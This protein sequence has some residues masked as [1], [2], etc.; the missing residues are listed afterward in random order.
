MTLTDKTVVPEFDEID[1]AW[2]QVAVVQA[3]LAANPKRDERATDPPDTPQFS[4]LASA[5]IRHLSA[6]IGQLEELRNV[7]EPED[8]YG[9][10]RPT[11]I[12]YERARSLL[13]DAAISAARCGRQIPYGCVSTDSEGG[14]RVEWVRPTASVHLVVPAS[15]RR[16][17]YIYHEVND[18]YATDS[19]SPKGL[20][21]WLQEI[22]EIT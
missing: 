21:R 17:P 16:L 13:V 8:E 18:S 22:Q 9:I 14:V 2:A 20:A 3:R 7:E 4:Q 19:A 6:L 5:G 10:L 11:D 12:A 15:S 1:L